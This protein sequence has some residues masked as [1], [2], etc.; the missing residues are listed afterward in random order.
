[1]KRIEGTGI[2]VMIYEL[3]MSD[4]NSTARTVLCDL[5]AFCQDCVVVIVNRVQL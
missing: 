4:D 2:M 1:M 3:A 5:G